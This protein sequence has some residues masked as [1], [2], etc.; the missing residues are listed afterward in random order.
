M[1]S[2]KLFQLVAVALHAA[3]VNAQATSTDEPLLDA[4]DIE[5]V[6]PTQILAPAEATSIAAVADSFIASI[7]SAPEFSSVV[8]VLATGV[9]VTAQEAIEADPTN[10][11][12]DLLRGSPPP[13]WATAL[14][15]S[16]GEYIQ[17]VAEDAAQIVTSDF[18]GLYT[19]VSSD[20]AALETGAAASSGF[21]YPTG[22]SGRSNYTAP[23]PTGSAAAPGP[24][25]QAFP[26]SANSLRV[27]SITAFVVA[28]GMGVGAWLLF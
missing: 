10:F 22:G 13:S 21:A 4:S 18:A 25:T 11:V 27:G 17:S 6:V 23:R 8:S 1:Q 9:P 2:K 20:V 7:T 12:L 28:A 24:S 5:D 16:V 19:S 15:P 26:G 14:P 3:A